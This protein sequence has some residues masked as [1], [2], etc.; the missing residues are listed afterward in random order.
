MGYTYNKNFI[1]LIYTSLF[2]LR[3]V[4]MKQTFIQKII[5]LFYV[6]ESY[7]HLVNCEC[8]QFNTLGHMLVIYLYCFT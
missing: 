7:N 5:N 4:Q 6:Y 8:V 2:G 1:K 3:T